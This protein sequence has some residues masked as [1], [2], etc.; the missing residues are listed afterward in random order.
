MEGMENVVAAI[1]NMRKDMGITPV[2]QLVQKTLMCGI[3]KARQICRG[4][5]RWNV[6]ALDKKELIKMIRKHGY[7]VKS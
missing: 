7:K 2:D 6:S 3:S 4:D 1:A 5:Y